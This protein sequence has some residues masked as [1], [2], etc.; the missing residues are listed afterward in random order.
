MISFFK[1][2]GDPREKVA[3]LLSVATWDFHSSAPEHGGGV[4]VEVLLARSERFPADLL[5]Q[6]ATLKKYVESLSA[7]EA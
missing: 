4:Q 6:V 1:Y 7:L 5:R 2:S 3:I